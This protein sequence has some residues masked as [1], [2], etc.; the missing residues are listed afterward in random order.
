[1]PLN[2]LT[3]CDALVTL[4]SPATLNTKSGHLF[5]TGLTKIH[6]GSMA[7]SHIEVFEL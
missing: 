3:Q 6:V 1:M 7:T 2:V 4:W 5:F